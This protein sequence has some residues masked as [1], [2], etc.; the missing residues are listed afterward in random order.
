MEFRC[1]CHNSGTNSFTG[2]CDRCGIT[3]SYKGTIIS[4]STSIDGLLI[5]VQGG[6]LRS[7]EKLILRTPN[8][9]ELGKAVRELFS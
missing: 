7:I 3:K 4:N 1:N 2:K 6:I 8:D 5:D 9:M